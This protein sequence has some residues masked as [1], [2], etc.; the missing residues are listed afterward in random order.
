MD[1]RRRL[2]IAIGVGLVGA[3]GGCGGTLQPEPPGQMAAS[4]P[5]GSTMLTYDKDIAPLMQACAGCHPALNPYNPTTYAGII[6]NGS[7]G[8]P[9]VIAGDPDHSL[10]VTKL[11]AGHNG[12]PASTAQAVRAWVTAGA[13]QN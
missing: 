13:K 6:A 11:E 8:M 4:A 7:S 1:W 9:N 3:L 10:L 2:G 5:S 12:I